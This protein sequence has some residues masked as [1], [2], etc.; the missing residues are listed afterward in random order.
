LRSSRAAAV[1]AVPS[2]A[3]QPLQNRAPSG[4]ALPQAGHAAMRGSIGAGTHRGK[5]C[6]RDPTARV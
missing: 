1:A 4:F 2:F 3:A 5:G 6:V